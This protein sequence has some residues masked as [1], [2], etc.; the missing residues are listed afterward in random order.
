MTLNEVKEYLKLDDDLIEDDELIKGLIVAAKTY[1]EDSTGKAYQDSELYNLAVMMV[2]AHWY[3]NRSIIHNKT[4]VNELP[5]SFF[6]I[7]AQIQWSNRYKEVV[8][9]G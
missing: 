3:E 1:I 6:A 4:V 7:V 2:V 8:R 5:Q 9:H